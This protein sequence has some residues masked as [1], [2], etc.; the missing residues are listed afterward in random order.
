MSTGIKTENAEALKRMKLVLEGLREIRSLAKKHERRLEVRRRR[1]EQR[2]RARGL[3][4]SERHQE[5]ERSA[6]PRVSPRK[7][8]FC[9][10]R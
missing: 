1:R 2:T 5:P 9:R 3:E 7:H 6:F 10:M 4:V 8:V